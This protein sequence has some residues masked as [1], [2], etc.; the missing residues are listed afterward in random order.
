MKFEIVRNDIVNMEV[1]AIVLPA[2]TKLHEGSGVSKRIFEKAG[3]KNLEK[4]CKKLG[5]QKLE[6]LCLLLDMI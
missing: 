3:R 2:N 6:Q 1:D 4:A 5:K